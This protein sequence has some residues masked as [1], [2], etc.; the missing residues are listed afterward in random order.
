[1]SSDFDPTLDD[2]VIFDS[3]DL[4]AQVR[5]AGFDP[6]PGGLSRKASSDSVK[7]MA[8]GRKGKLSASLAKAK[9]SLVTA[10]GST[11]GLLDRVADK[12]SAIDRASKKSAKAFATPQSGDP[13]M[14]KVL[15]S[16]DGFVVADDDDDVPVPCTPKCVDDLVMDDVDMD[17]SPTRPSLLCDSLDLPEIKFSEKLPPLPLSKPPSAT[18]ST[19]KD[20]D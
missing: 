16:L 19:P 8:P 17:L 18:T 13:E 1:M 14:D 3:H 6:T 4:T 15:S 7:T 2:D 12:F 5:A 11:K 9:L 10:T 20:N